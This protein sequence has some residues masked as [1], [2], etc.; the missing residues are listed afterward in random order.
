MLARIASLLV[1]LVAKNGV[2]LEDVLQLTDSVARAFMPADWI[3]QEQETKPIRV[4][5]EGLAAF[6]DF[7][8]KAF[9]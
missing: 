4:D 5:V 2:K 1:L 9:G 7:A 6:Q 8:A 3:G